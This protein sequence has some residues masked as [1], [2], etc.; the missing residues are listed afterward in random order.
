MTTLVNIFFK[1]FIKKHPFQIEVKVS[2]EEI[3][4]S[5]SFVEAAIIRINFKYAGVNITEEKNVCI[6]SLR[7]A[8]VPIEVSCERREREMSTIIKI[9]DAFK[10][11]AS[12]ATA[13][14]KR[15]I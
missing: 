7:Q 15:E 10:S 13:K 11:L 8:N 14:N 5:R 6:F 4:H 12:N 1:I 3:H 2:S 9:L